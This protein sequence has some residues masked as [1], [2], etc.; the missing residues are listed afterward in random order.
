MQV[1]VG[2]EMAG[3]IRWLFALEQAAVAGRVNGPTPGE[4]LDAE[5]AQFGQ[6]A[7][8]VVVVF[9]AVVDHGVGVGRGA[10]GSAGIHRWAFGFPATGVG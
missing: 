5:V 3:E 2:V 8:R 7:A 4:R 1:A 10:V 6:V 9:F